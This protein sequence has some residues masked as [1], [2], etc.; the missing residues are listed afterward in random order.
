MAGYK[1]KGIRDNEK[2]IM[3]DLKRLMSRTA[4]TEREAQML[5]GIISQIEESLRKI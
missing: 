5:H 1:P 2:E 3:M 4:I